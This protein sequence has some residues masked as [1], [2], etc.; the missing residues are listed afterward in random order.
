[1]IHL[2]L[3]FHKKSQAT[4]KG[5]RKETA[6]TVSCFSKGQSP[7]LDNMTFKEIYNWI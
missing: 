7:L 2:A 4:P 6:V 5:S 3:L 1:M